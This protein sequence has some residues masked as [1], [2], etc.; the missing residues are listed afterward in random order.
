M[1]PPRLFKDLPLFWRHRTWRLALLST[2]VVAAI[3]AVSGGFRRAGSTD[4]PLPVSGA[5]VP[6]ASDAF[7]VTPLCAWHSDT[8]PGQRA[9]QDDAQRYLILRTRVVSKAR[10]WVAMRA[11]LDKDVVWL[12]EGHGDPVAAE[13][14]QRA[15]DAT[16]GQDLGPGLPVVIDFVWEL[17]A[18]MAPPATSTWGL[19]K[20]RFIERTRASGESM[21]VQDGPGWKFVLPVAQA[22]PGPAA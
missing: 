3:V 18:G 14:S 22:C 7:V 10:D 17:P 20:R 12:P 13:R 9:P 6:I 1:E 16:L 4:R 15:D 8:R 5:D 2:V 11:Y 19:F 21:W